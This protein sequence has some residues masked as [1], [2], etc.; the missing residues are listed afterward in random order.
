MY[1]LKDILEAKA[2]VKEQYQTK[3]GVSYLIIIIL[4]AIIVKLIIN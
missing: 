3:L 4:I 2:L 1:T